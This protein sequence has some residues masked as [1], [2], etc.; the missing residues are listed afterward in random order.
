[1]SNRL[2][3]SAEEAPV[4]NHDEVFAGECASTAP[5]G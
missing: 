2:F 5:L 3:N 4:R 1:M